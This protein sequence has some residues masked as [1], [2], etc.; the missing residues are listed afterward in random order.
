MSDRN[1]IT[2]TITQNLGGKPWV[3]V[4]TPPEGAPPSMLDIGILLRGIVYCETVKY[5][6][7]PNN[8]L[9]WQRWGRLPFNYVNACFPLEARYEQLCERFGLPR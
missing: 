7:D 9:D 1:G 4:R 3:W 6:G 2:I 8:P 5:G